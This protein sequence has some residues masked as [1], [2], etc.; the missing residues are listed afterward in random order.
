MAHTGPW[1]HGVQK[2]PHVAPALGPLGFPRNTPWNLASAR[3]PDHRRRTGRGCEDMGTTHLPCGFLRAQ[4][5]VSARRRQVA[6]AVG[7]ASRGRG[8]AC[9]PGVSTLCL[10]ALVAL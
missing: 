1:S 3:F 5:D 7:L 8:S 2:H 4:A 9:E 10:L 6:I